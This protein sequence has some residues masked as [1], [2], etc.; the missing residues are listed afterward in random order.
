MADVGQSCSRVFCP[1][2]SE[3]SVLLTIDHDLSPFRVCLK[4]ERA[5][6]ME[7]LLGGEIRKTE[8]QPSSQTLI[9][10]GALNDLTI[11]ISKA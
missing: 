7:R 1:L 3:L 10:Q 4:S 2:P 6:E 9:V 5:R 11:F 8:W